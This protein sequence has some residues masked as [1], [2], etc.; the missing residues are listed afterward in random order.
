MVLPVAEEILFRGYLFDALK[1]YLPDVAVVILTALG[2]SLIH[3][4]GL[5]VA[6]IFGFGLVQGWLRLRTGSIWLPVLMHVMNNGLLV[7]VSS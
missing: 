2:F 4:Q 7:A 6:P 5:Y 3:F 1:K